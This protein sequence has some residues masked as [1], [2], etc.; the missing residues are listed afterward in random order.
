M[1][2][3]WS[4]I[5]FLVIASLLICG[6]S[7]I[8]PVTKKVYFSWEKQQQKEFIEEAEKYLS[9]D[10]TVFY[11]NRDRLAFLDEKGD[12]LI[13]N[14]SIV[15]AD[16]PR[17]C[18][19]PIFL[20]EQK[21]SS[22][23]IQRFDFGRDSFFLMRRFSN[24]KW[25]IAAKILKKVYPFGAFAFLLLYWSCSWLFYMRYTSPIK[26][27]IKTIRKY[28]EGKEEFLPQIEFPA[29]DTRD[30]FAKLISTLN[31]LSAKIQHQIETLTYQKD[32]HESILDSLVEGIVAVNAQNR[33]TYANPVATKMLGTSKF[34]LVGQF[35]LQE[36]PTEL[37]YQCDQL[38]ES[39][40]R[41]NLIQHQSISLAKAK[42]LHLDILAIPRAF[43]SGAVL[44]LQDKTSDVKMLEMG[45][46]FIANASHEL[47]TPITIIRGFAE[48][49]H[50]QK[51]LSEKLKLEI[52][53]KIVSTCERLSTL[54]QNL[55]TL[56][57]I[58]NQPSSDHETFDL[59]S[60][61]ENCIYMME[62]LYPK[63][64]L[65]LTTNEN[66]Y[67]IQGNSHLIEHAITNLIDN[68]IKYSQSPQK[69]EIILR[70]NEDQTICD[71]K[72]EG[73]GIPSED[74]THIFDRFYTV[75]KARSRK[76][77]GAGLGLSIVKTIIDKQNAQIEVNSKIG[78]GTT[79]TLSFPQAKLCDT[80]LVQM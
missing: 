67:L 24:D 48:T 16:Y 28:Q 7:F 69:I 38:V 72:D 45:R 73:I 66:E 15:A 80:H 26:A 43:K 42:K 76:H 14:G 33:V 31:S 5:D 34:A 68:A 36:N 74:L 60:I 4:V 21:G 49:L 70:K 22:K 19:E 50:E 57:D 79:F 46:E 27:V 35:L 2:K 44:V 61:V 13:G 53:D 51:D 3:K 54:V 64:K 32:E 56:A 20:D 17:D 63:A 6:F 55:L 12:L 39:C 29:M 37:L 18:Y 59:L 78:M 71:I 47:R 62:Q 65:I 8:Q 41:E 11:Q 30:E 9:G 23:I 75:D 1:Q 25:Q 58:D 77:G 10:Q 40:Q 52:I